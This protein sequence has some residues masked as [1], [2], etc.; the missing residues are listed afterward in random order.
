MELKR[1]AGVI[2]L[3]PENK[4][5]LQRRTKD[6]L[7]YPNYWTLPGGKVEDNETVERALEREIKEE[8]GVKIENYQLFRKETERNTDSIVERH[9]FWS[10]F[11]HNI[12]HLKLGE[13]SALR[14]FSDVEITSQNCFQAQEIHK[15]IL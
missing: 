3:N 1:F 8:L 4:I 10:R 15:T 11:D 5:L 2:F 14:Y 7:F 9:I 12:E 13:A 6:A